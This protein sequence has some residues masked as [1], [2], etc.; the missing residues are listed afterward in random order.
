MDK[1]KW[2][3]ERVCASYSCNKVFFKNGFGVMNGSQDGVISPIF[4]QRYLEDQK[5]NKSMF[6]FLQKIEARILNWACYQQ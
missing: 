4:F 5:L 2:I 6:I 3:T 1:K